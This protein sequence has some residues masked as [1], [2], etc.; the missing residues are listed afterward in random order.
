MHG[1]TYILL[2]DE[3]DRI[4]QASATMTKEAASRAMRATLARLSEQPDVKD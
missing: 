4:I 2:I 3:G 1:A